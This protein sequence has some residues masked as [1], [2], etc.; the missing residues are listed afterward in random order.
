MRITALS[1]FPLKIP[2]D[3]PYLQTGNVDATMPRSD[4]FRMPNYRAIYSRNMET[5]LVR[6]D[7]DEGVTGWGE[8]LVP[9]A[10]EATARIVEA[11]LAP[12]LLGQDPLDSSPLYSSMYDSMRDR[13]HY[14]GFMVDAIS[15]CEIALWDIRGKYSNLP[16]YRL[17][18]GAYR[19]QIPA[20]VSGLPAAGT[21]QRI[22]LAQSWVERGFSAL[23]HAGGYGVEADAVEM[24][25]L[26]EALG[27]A[28]TLMLDA[29][30]RYSIAEA[31]ALGRKLEQSGVAL[32]EAPAAPEDV[33]GHAELARALDIPVAIGEAERTRYAFLPWLINRAADVLQPDVG[34]CGIGETTRIAALAESFNIPIMLHQSVGLGIA[35]AAGLHVAAATSNLLYLEFQPTILP[36]ANQILQTPLICERGFWH[37]PDGAGL[38][39]EA[40]LDAIKRYAVEHI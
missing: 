32:L 6:I 3:V 8:A 7:T 39:I 17:L 33:A 4:Y 35:V 30:W 40:N 34:R 10:P 18:G 25:A 37:L 14:G 11:L 2:R 28:I 16:V 1:T 22:A 9:V 26:R 13:G 5:L 36:L 20:Y 21:E 31:L 29:H 27:N 15:A 19:E 23:K 24:A 38:G 12:L